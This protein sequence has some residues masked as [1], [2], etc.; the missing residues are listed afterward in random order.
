MKRT[1]ALLLVFCSCMMG[2]VTAFRT[3]RNLTARPFT[4]SELR[5]LFIGH[6]KQSAIVEEPGLCPDNWTFPEKSNPHSTAFMMWNA[7]FDVAAQ[8]KCTF[9]LSEPDVCAALFVDGKAVASWKETFPSVM[10][11]EGTH[12]IQ[13][14][15][16]QRKGEKL[17]KILAYRDGY[18]TKL[19]YTELKL[20][21]KTKAFLFLQTGSCLALSNEKA[22][23]VDA[24]C[25]VPAK[26]VDTRARIADMPSVAGQGEAV[27]VPLSLEYPEI[28]APLL[29]A[30]DV[31]VDYETASGRKL[32][33]ETSS[34]SGH[35][36]TLTLG[37]AAEAELVKM[38]FSV[39]GKPV[40]PGCTLHIVEAQSK[41]HLR[42]C[43]K[44]L[45]IGDE[46][47]LLITDK[48]SKIKM[49]ALNGGDVILDMLGNADCLAT[50]QKAFPNA[51]VQTFLP[52]PG[53]LPELC[54]LERLPKDACR[55]VLLGAFSP[56][57]LAFICR[58]CAA[59]GIVPVAVALP[60]D[61]LAA[62]SVKET[63]LR[64]GV[65]VLDLWSDMM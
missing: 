29:A 62:L 38:T 46:R 34:V 30:V 47:A 27:E 33:S 25:I 16:A 10:L 37:P 1:L 43:G 31:Q 5:L 11:E 19:K 6:G 15:A 21:K 48:K 64:L 18:A 40:F 36:P 28:A 14:L 22:I 39:K 63:S 49:P 51:K 9:R 13:M 17:P 42:A 41:F 61:R 8:G 53:T 3:V 2:Q 58:R 26:R 20:D 55:L 23:A 59:S 24:K 4:A 7:T 65:D 35:K 54:A 56:D 32:G 45:F 50:A 12:T 60:G 52:T 57:M 44:S